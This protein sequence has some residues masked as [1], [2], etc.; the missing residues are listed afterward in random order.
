MPSPSVRA[1]IIVAGVVAL[2]GCAQTPVTSTGSSSVGGSTSSG[3]SSVTSASSSS[4]VASSAG[5]TSSSSAGTTSAGSSSGVSSSSSA[6]TS[7]GAASS[8]GLAGR[9]VPDPLYGVTLDE[10]TNITAEIASLSQLVRMPTTRVYFDVQEPASYYVSP[11]QQLNSTTFLMG[12]LIDSSDM[13][14]VTTAAAAQT[15]A[16]QFT[17]ALGSSI[18]I[19]E[20]GNEVN[21]DWLDTGTQPTLGKVEAMYDV[22]A[23]QGGATALTFFYEGEPSDPDNC[24]ATDDGGNDMFTWINQQFDLADP[25]ASRPAASEQLRTGLTYVLVSWYP[26][27]CPGEDPDWTTVYDQLATVFPNSKV[28]FGELGTAN[29]QAGSTFEQNEITTYYPMAATVTLPSSYVG[30]YFWWYYAEE[31]VPTTETVLFGLLNAAIQ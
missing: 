4:T 15:R 29:P 31:M 10:V 1:L 26:D 6:G 21:G 8:G 12:E 27:Q 28:G 2:L 24:I 18:D 20:V 17:S 19:W 16:Q 7:S 11:V 3:G 30:G 5:T 22:V 13:A 25:V 9:A 14:S 23:G